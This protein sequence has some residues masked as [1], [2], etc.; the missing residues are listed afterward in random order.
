MAKAGETSAVAEQKPAQLRSRE[1]WG[2]PVPGDDSPPVTSREFEARWPSVD[3][4]GCTRTT[5]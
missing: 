1:C 3:S 5:P 4:G 2:A